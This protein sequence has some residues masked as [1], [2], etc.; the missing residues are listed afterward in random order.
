MQKLVDSSITD[1][2][3][4]SVEICIISVW[5]DQF[6]ANPLSNVISRLLIYPWVIGETLRRMVYSIYQQVLAK[7]FHLTD[8]AV[9]TN[10]E[11]GGFA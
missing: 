9:D 11:S 5:R 8:H 7:L 4:V 2:A 10:T 6:K 1:K 3:V